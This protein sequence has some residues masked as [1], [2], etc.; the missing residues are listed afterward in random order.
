MSLLHINTAI[1]LAEPSL[2][3]QQLE[4]ERS[5]TRRDSSESNSGHKIK[6]VVLGALTG[7]FIQ[8]LSLGAYNQNLP[9]QI[10]YVSIWR[11]CACTLMWCIC[12]QFFASEEDDFEA[13]KSSSGKNNEIIKRRYFFLLGV[14]CFIGFV[15][16]TFGACSAI[17]VYL[18]FPIPFN[19]ILTIVTVGFVFCYL[20]V[21]CY[22]LGKNKRRRAINN[23]DS[24]DDED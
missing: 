2:E 12:S 23:D 10:V 17:D 1:P 6:L 5:A 8:V 9:F 21:W 14:Y 3:H 15:L 13:K 16:G 19:P 22:D 18:G 7:F 4:E 24:D 20:M 11:A